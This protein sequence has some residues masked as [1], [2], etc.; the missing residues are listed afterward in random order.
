MDTAYAAASRL[1]RSVKVAARVTYLKEQA[2]DQT[3]AD[4]AFILELLVK[5][6]L[7]AREVKQFAASN[8]AAELLGR[9]WDMFKGNLVLE[10]KREQPVR[11]VSSMTSNELK[12]YREE[13]L[14]RNQNGAVTG[15]SLCCATSLSEAAARIILVK[16]HHGT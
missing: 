6:A 16:L 1:L 2:A 7:D 11:D 12:A 15:S 3:I 10:D 5:N 8:R 14:R 4:K 13:L 9:E